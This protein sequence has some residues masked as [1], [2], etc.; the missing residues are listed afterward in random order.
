MSYSPGLN[1]SPPLPALSQEGLP[2][3]TQQP[4][5]GIFSSGDSVSLTCQTES[6]VDTITWY[7]NE[8][9]VGSETNYN[10]PSFS[11]DVAGNYTCRATTN[12]VGTVTSALAELQL[13]GRFTITLKNTLLKGS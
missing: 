13:A 9:L 1:L 11:A 2:V 6:A 3:I 10:I 5:G 7:R 12:V 8:E 4:Q